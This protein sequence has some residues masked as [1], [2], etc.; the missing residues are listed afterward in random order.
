MR[1]DRGS[2]RRGRFGI[3]AVG[4]QRLQDLVGQPDRSQGVFAAD[5][6]TRQPPRCIHEIF[7]LERQRFAASSRNAVDPQHLAEEVLSHQGRLAQVDTFEVEPAPLELFGG[8][9]ESGL[10]GGKVE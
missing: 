10:F 5:S 7:Q 6:G 8:P 2:G 9:N 1:L 4:F 3:P